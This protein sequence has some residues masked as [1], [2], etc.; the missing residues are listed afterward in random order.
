MLPSLA[1]SSRPEKEFRASA[2]QVN[3]AALSCCQA[4]GIKIGSSSQG[5]RQKRSAAPAELIQS[6]QVNFMECQTKL[7]IESPKGTGVY[8]FTFKVGL[9]LQDQQPP[10]FLMDAFSNETFE[11]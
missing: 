1:R 10:V 8:C 9:S 4:S 6:S 3:D 2:L 5:T 11:G 7:L